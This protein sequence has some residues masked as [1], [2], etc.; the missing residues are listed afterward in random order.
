MAGINGTWIVVFRS[1]LGNY[2]SLFV[3]KD[4]GTYKKYSR[5]INMPGDTRA[6][7]Y[8]DIF[9][10]GIGNNQYMRVYANYLGTICNLQTP[11]EKTSTTTMKIKY[12]LVN[13]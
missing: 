4:D 3:I 2:G 10:I 11:F 13:T 8:K 9:N 6:M 5:S 12:T 7:I 1:T